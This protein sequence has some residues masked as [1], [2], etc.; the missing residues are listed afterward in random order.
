MSAQNLM[1]QTQKMVGKK[2]WRANK[3]GKP[4]TKLGGPMHRRPTRSAATVV[5]GLYA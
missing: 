2:T 5:V 4:N 3:L 1:G